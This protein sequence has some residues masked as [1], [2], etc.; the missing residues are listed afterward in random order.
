MKKALTITGSAFLRILKFVK[1]GVK[2]Y[3]AESELSHEFIRKGAAGSAY[4]PIVATGKNACTLHYTQNNGTCRAGDLLLLDFGAEYFNYAADCSRTI[5]VSGKFTPRQ[6]DCYN[7]V[8]RVLK[9]A[10]TLAVPGTSINEL[11][12]KTGRLLEKEMLRLGL[13]TARDVRNQPK[14][15]PVYKR[16]FMHGISHFIGLDV[17]DVGFKH[18]VLKKGMVL[19]CE[20]ALYI[21]EE[22]LGIRLENELLVDKTPV[23][24]SAEIPVEPEE[25]EKLMRR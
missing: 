22:N 20:P 4:L 14:S 11:N 19:S 24:L 23:N 6:K 10:M 13:F 2:E 3:E 21:P 25:I 15:K 9:K 7:A 1:P 16:Y 5:P 18:T 8:L 17:H 12:K